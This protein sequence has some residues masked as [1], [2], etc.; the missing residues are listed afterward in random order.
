[1]RIETDEV[2]ATLQTEVTILKEAFGY[3]EN[4]TESK[5]QN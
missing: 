2:K 5:V 1:V 4:H 3:M